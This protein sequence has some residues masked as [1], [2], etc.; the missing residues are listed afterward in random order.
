MLTYCRKHRGRIQFLVVYMLDRF[1]RNQYDHHALKAYL[2][3]LG[4]TLRAVAQPIDDSATGQ[5]MDGILA[6]FN[7]FDNNVRR[8]RCTTG[9]KAAANRGRWVFPTPLGYRKA[10]KPDGEKTLELHP[11]TAPFIRQAFEMAASG[12]HG[13]GDILR[14]LAGAG[15]PAAGAVR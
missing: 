8:E 15:S 14:E 3:K 12:L 6:A 9:M 1:A 4:I 7:E 11:E 13:V 10:L 5:L 2:Q